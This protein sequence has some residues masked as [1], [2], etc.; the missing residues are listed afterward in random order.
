[1]KAF[2]PVPDLPPHPPHQAQPL[3][4]NSVS[5]PESS[6]RQASVASEVID[7]KWLSYFQRCSRL[8]VAVLEP[9]TLTLRYANDYFRQ[10]T[11]VTID[12]IGAAPGTPRQG[13]A[14][15]NLLSSADNAAVQQLYRRH[16]LHL[17]FR[18]FYQ[19]HPHG[20][21]ILDEPVMVAIASPDNAEPRYVELWLRS[22]RL[23]INRID[24]QLDEFAD[25]HLHQSS[26]AD[27]EARLADPHQVQELAQ[28]LQLTNYQIEGQML[29]EGLDVTAQETIR[30]I[31]Q[32]LIDRDSIL[33]SDKFQQ[34]N[35]HMRL[36]FRA[37]NTAILSVEGDYPEGGTAGH[38][39]RLFTGNVE[40]SVDSQVLSLR[41][42]QGSHLLRAMEMNRVVVVPDLAADC[43]TDLGR[44]VLAMG[45][46]S[47]LIIPLVADM[48][49]WEESTVA[50]E[51]V[52][53][54]GASSLPPIVGL[55]ALLSHRPHNFDGLDYRHATQLI[56]AFT[57][58]LTAAYRQVIQQR[59][60][61]NIH[62]AVEWRFAQEAERR[63][64][65]LLPQPIVFPGVYPLYGISDI[66]GSSEA[67]NQAIQADLLTQFKLGLA[68]VEAA[69]HCQETALGEQ[70]RLDLL[71]HAA[72]LQEKLTVDAEVTGLRYLRERLEAYF[73][74]F[75]QCGPAAQTAVAA[76]RAACDNEH[77]CVYEARAAYDRAITQITTLLRDTWDKWQQQMQ[78]ITPHYCDLEVTDGIDH[79]VY[80]G[81]SIDPNF[82]LFHL[83]SLR[84][85]QLRAV[86]DCARMALEA[87]SHHD[88]ELSVTHLVLVQ[89]LTVDIFHDEKTERLFDVRGSRDT[90]YEIVKKRIDKAVDQETKTRITQPGKLT[91]VYSTQEEWT[92]YQQYLTYLIREGWVAPTIE[93]GT[94]E[95]LQ[96]VD[97]L[98][99]AR[100]QIRADS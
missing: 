53:P 34:I 61:A 13:N 46:R 17:V 68:V 88:T 87:Q 47:L 59:F 4:D 51:T 30:R 14:L 5:R 60:I 78:Q 92:E 3:P 57:T 21:R 11:G 72:C 62:P 35:Q 90:R 75:S 27:L 95:P 82:S 86:C 55:V 1:M 99:F 80:A 49:G 93:M 26:L 28:R 43:H 76:Y 20:L 54:T 64:L 41:D 42:L 32:L 2:E 73:D 18:D 79:M 38:R 25:L 37:E 24:P 74:Y 70:L 100:V 77:Q 33:R 9:G 7:T 6:L 50:D 96:G 29:L 98:K 39:L 48:E 19:V 10:F 58:A 52:E 63:S 65:G 84:Y 44:R 89:D 23:Q 16:V 56:P 40:S 66:R 31:T 69:C 22:E 81:A 94:V 45:I 91:L 85:E 15:L 97:G 8:L 36:L 83:H 12:P 71:E 67:R